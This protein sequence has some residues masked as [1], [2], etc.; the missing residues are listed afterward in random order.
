MPTPP[1]LIAFPGPIVIL[2]FGSIGQGTLPVLL[3]DM[4][5]QPSQVTV[6]AKDADG[7]DIA[8]E[9]GVTHVLEALTRKN[10]ESV[11][12]KYLAGGGFLVN[13]SVE[14]ESLALIKYCGKRRVLYIDTVTEPWAGRSED[15]SLSA[16]RRSNYA[17]REEVLAYARQKANG[18]TAVITMGANPGLASMRAAAKP[19]DADFLFFVRKPDKIHHFFTASESE[20]FAK[21][22]EYGFGCG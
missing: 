3:R 20:F 7:A 13:V 9:Y 11:L 16:S 6:I 21:A 4:D 15:P 19:A 12:D 8:K 18:P 5:V 17:L 10:F 14:V 2:G 1:K 22:C